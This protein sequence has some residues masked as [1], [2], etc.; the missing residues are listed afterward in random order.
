MIMRAIKTAEPAKSRAGTG[1]RSSDEETPEES[2][3]LVRQELWGLGNGSPLDHLFGSAAIVGLTPTTAFVVVCHRLG[4]R[5]RRYAQESNIW[6]DAYETELALSQARKTKASKL[7]LVPWSPT[8]NLLKKDRYTICV[9]FEPGAIG[10]LAT[11][12]GQCAQGLKRGGRLFAADVMTKAGESVHCPDGRVV[13][14]RAEHWKAAEAAGFAIERDLDMS[15]GLQASIR[16]GFLQSIRLLAEIRA[17]R[18]PCKLQRQSTYMIELETW[19]LIH[20]L[21]DR[22]LATA[23]GF[24]ATR[25]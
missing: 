3:L 6:V 2:S 10:E 18:G 12:Y 5:L 15:P 8:A 14:P 11:I 25:S 7:A 22:D 4:D 23:T 17:L 21:I 1:G 24:L 20:H 13:R 9:L 19:S 16:S